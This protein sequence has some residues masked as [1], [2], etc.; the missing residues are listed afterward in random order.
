MCVRRILLHILFKCVNVRHAWN[1]L[2]KN[3][4]IWKQTLENVM[5]S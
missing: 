2:V 5:F 3:I 1:H 4:K